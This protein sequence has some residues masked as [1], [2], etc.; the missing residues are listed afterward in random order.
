[1]NF[2]TIAFD[3]F[4]SW[5]LIAALAGGF[6]LLLILA[7]WLGLR[8]W[9]L[10]SLAALVLLA[11]LANPAYRQEDRTPLADI[12]F[13]LVDTTESQSL[14]ARQAQMDEALPELIAEL[15]EDP[16]DPIEIVTVTVRDTPSDAEERGTFLLRELAQAS[17]EVS[18]D[19]IAGAI[20]VTDGQVHDTDGLLNFPAPVH[21]LRTG[22]ASDWDRRISVVNGPAFGIV[23]E[24][25]TFTI[26][27]DDEGAV[28]ADIDGIAMI[29]ASL[30]GGTPQR[31]YAR[32]GEDI[33]LEMTLEHAGI[34]LLQFR[35][36]EARD[37]ITARN[38]A[39][40]LQVNGV[41][42]RLRVLL[43]S[44]EPYPGER[45]WRNLLK[46]DAAVDLVH[47]TILRSPDK[48]D[49][50]PVNELSLI[51]FPTRELFMDKVDEF[52]LII[53][54]RYRR[55]G[56]LP[57]LYI[58]N[59]ARYVRDGGAVLVASG[60]A[61]ASVESLARTPFREVLPAMPTGRIFEEGFTPT[62]SELGLRHPVT[63]ELYEHFELPLASDGTPAWGRWF[64]HVEL[65]ANGGFT[66]MT[67]VNNEPLLVL[68]RVGEGR[69]AVLG[70]DHAWLWSRG[71]EG[72]GPQLE[73]LRRLAHWLM[74]EPEL[75][76]EVLVA[77]ADG[78]AVTVERRSLGDVN[79]TITFTDP[80]GAP[81]IATFDLVSPG[82]WRT[83]F[84]ADVD[85]VYRITD[86]DLETVVAVGPASP[87]EFETP[88]GISAILAEQ[89]QE[90]GGG[91]YLLEDTGTPSVR[92]VRLDRVSAGSNW[93]GL[94]MRDAYTVDDI[95]L[96]SLA[97]GWIFLVLAALLSLAA[98][99]LE[100]R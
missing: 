23:G 66:V 7:A 33:D 21:V 86:G 10:R 100:G 3:P 84:T 31:F 50:V 6:V 96:S 4:V 27:V 16:N 71:F 40:I 61:F 80:A 18:P 43:V 72:G 85:G 17:V 2:A 34:N 20:L 58:E 42:D 22:S 87:K 44:G 53:F 45:T 32:P 60:P 1:M 67:G 82:R 79:P 57:D 59:I 90:T 76:E 95:R 92:R 64:R 11:G 74:Q 36:P 49:G 91:E 93:M 97:P 29:E 15:T 48:Q 8:G 65:Q 94:V 81:D 70:S 69:I 19:R 63:S 56:V 88:I 24:S 38:N 12:V 35:T 78:H 54:D 41:R 5:T 68:D 47:F 55:R 77:D 75:E 28:P 46:A 30:D 99:R 13:V 51:A 62:V 52:D 14:G 25:V 98:W 26:R 9:F 83:E 39:A 73:L 37:E 89:V